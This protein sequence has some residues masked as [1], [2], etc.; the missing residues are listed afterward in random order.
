VVAAAAVL[1]IG[2]L[3]LAPTVPTV[4]VVEVLAVVLE[5]VV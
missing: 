1:V 3:M 4:V 5:T 2:S